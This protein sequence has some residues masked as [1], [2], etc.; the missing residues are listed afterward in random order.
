MFTLRTCIFSTISCCSS[1]TPM[2]K[3][4]E[5]N[6]PNTETYDQSTKPN[7][8]PRPDADQYESFYN[9]QL[10]KKTFIDET[11]HIDELLNDLKR[12]VLITR[13]RRSFGTTTITLKDIL[14]AYF[15]GNCSH[16][17]QTKAQ[18]FVIDRIIE[19][20]LS[21]DDYEGCGMP[22]E[23]MSHPIPSWQFLS[24]KN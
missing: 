3:A 15:N 24:L 6:E 19:D 8:E 13:P 10:G 23:L 9:I 1:P 17:N 22:A 7:I 5:E 21:P 16:W 2:E 12:C 18:E 14:G 11:P 4:V 20:G